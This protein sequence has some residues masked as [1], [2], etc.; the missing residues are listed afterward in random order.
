M[1]ICRKEFLQQMYQFVD[2]WLSKR[3]PQQ[4]I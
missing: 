2:V 1:F 4:K 3:Q